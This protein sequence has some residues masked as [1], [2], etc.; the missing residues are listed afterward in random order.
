MIVLFALL[1]LAGLLLLFLPSL[2]IGWLCGLITEIFTGRK[3][4]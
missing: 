1:A 2:L 3:D 4:P